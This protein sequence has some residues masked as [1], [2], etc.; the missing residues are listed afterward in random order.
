MAL[1]PLKQKRVKRGRFDPCLRS[2]EHMAWV[3]SRFGC[4]VR[5]C[6]NVTD[7]I[8]P[9]HVTGIGGATIGRKP[10]DDRVIPLCRT[11]HQ[12][13]DHGIGEQLFAK[14]YEIDLEDMIADLK[15]E[16]PILKKLRLAS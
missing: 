6:T 3:R 2:P 4:A 9:A 16:S 14:K 8:D 12:E 13:M 1:P 7:R 11:H 5:G 15:R 10:P